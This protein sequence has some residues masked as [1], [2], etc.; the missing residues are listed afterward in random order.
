MAFRPE[1]FK[2]GCSLYGV[3]DLKLLLEQGHKFESRYMRKLKLQVH[4]KHLIRGRAFDGLMIM[5]INTDKL[6][7]K[8]PE[9]QQAYYDR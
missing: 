4:V 2:A 9:E 7:G 3:T 8:Y 6:I 5:S 1:V